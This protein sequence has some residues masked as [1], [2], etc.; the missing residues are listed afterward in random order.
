MSRDAAPAGHGGPTLLYSSGDRN[1][2]TLHPLAHCSPSSAD[3][4]TGKFE[5]LPVACAVIICKAV[6]L[7][8]SSGRA[9]CDRFCL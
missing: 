4:L 6:E 8:P 1:P 7:S 3:G 5:E 2:G 9:A